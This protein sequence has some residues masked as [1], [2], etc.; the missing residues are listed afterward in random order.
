M[1]LVAVAARDERGVLAWVTS[2]L[3]RWEVN[4]KGFVVD[5]AGMQLLVSDLR[6]LCKA[7]DE[8]GFLYRVTEVNEVILEDRPGTLAALCQELADQ[9]IGIC[10]AFGVSTG[11]GAGRIYLDVTDWKRAEPIL[12]AH[13]V[14][15]TPPPTNL[16]TIPAH[17]G[18]GRIAPIT[19]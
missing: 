12:S 11:G 13:H 8:M 9:G 15:A 7:L 4:L 19:R 10:T 14:E 17:P 3:A 1:Y 2:N 18:L 6:A 5:P 16:G